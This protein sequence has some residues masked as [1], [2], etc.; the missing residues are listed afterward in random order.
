M[1]NNGLIKQWMSAPVITVTPETSLTEA[2]ELLSEEH[3]R[4][5][6]VVKNN[7]LVGIITRRGLLR[8]DLSF[9]V[10]ES[11]HQRANMTEETVSDVMTDNP[12][13]IRPDSVIP[14]AARIMLENKITALPVLEKGE[15]VGIVT[16]SDFLRFIIEEYPT[17]KKTI[18]V[19]NYMSDEVVTVERDTTLLEAHRLMGVKRIRSLPVVEGDKLVG[20]VT[21]TDLMSSDPSRLASSQKQD[22]S[23]KVLTQPVEKVMSAPLYSISPEAPLPE[24]ARLMLENKVHCLPV[25]DET[26]QLV[27]IITESDLFLMIVQKFF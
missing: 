18:L 11:W 8:V 2:R 19:K 10:D 9:L 17:L 7:K 1:I 16:N 22:L 15:L 13:V 25:L 20:M 27:G 21:R 4:A 5:L 12:L 24:A 14:K 6:P 23:L 26:H 3:I